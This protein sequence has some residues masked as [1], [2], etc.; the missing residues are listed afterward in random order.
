[1]KKLEPRKKQFAPKRDLFPGEYIIDFNATKAARR[2]GFSAKTAYSQGQ[3]LLKNVEIQKRLKE[4]IRERSERTEITADR[5]LQE[6][7]ILAFSD[8]RNYITID[9]DTK[10]IKAK[11][12]EDMPPDSSRALEA[13]TENRTIHEDAKG[14]D[15]IVNEKVTFKLHS[16][17]KALELAMQHLGMLITK[18]DAPGLESALDRHG[19]TIEAL[20]KS[21]A[22]YGK[23][24]G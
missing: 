23:V 9:K 8:L 11:A 16:K 22:A 24:K 7:A 3:R 13:I 4:L 5:V 15:S 20:R 19:M 10:A 12:F 2:C 1:M 21:F 17:I 6:L 14:E 18:V